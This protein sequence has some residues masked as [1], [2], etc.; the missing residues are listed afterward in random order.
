LFHGRGEPRAEHR[1]GSPRTKLFGEQLNDGYSRLAAEDG[2]VFGSVHPYLTL[3]AMYY[4]LKTGYKGHFY[5]DTF[6]QRTDPI[7]EAE[8]NIQRVKYFWKAA[9]RLD[10]LNVE[11]QAMDKCSA[12][13]SLQMMDDAL[14]WARDN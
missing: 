9:K 3:E 11:N 6:P 14:A 13:V 10:Q 1:H 2:L 8:T 12:L 5:F 4:L 7:Q